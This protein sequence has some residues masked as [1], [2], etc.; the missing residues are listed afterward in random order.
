MDIDPI[1][2]APTTLPATDPPENHRA[3]RAKIGRKS[4]GN[5]AA[6]GTRSS[7]TLGEEH[8]RTGSRSSTPPPDSVFQIAG[9]ERSFTLPELTAC[10]KSRGNPARAPFEV[11]RVI[12]AFPPAPGAF[13][14][15]G[16][17]VRTSPSRPPRASSSTSSPLRPPAYSI[18][19][20]LRRV[21]GRG[22]D[23]HV[24]T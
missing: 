20:N 1:S 24:K 13:E 4:L 5:K 18:R 3:L 14:R 19:Q 17:T 7:M 8:M 11:G 10:A 6:S 22:I 9:H 21:L 12:A 23:G 16:P 15:H 2:T